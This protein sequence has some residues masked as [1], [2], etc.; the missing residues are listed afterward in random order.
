MP[1]IILVSLKLIFVAYLYLFVWQTARA[2]AAH[3]GTGQY[4]G[5]SRPGTGL[6]V[7]HSDTQTGLTVDVRQPTVL[8]SGE[9]ADVVIE[10]A[11]ASKVHVRLVNETGVLSLYDLGSTTGT[12]VNG[13]R[14]GAPLKLAKGDSVQIGKTVMEVT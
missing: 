4:R 14:V 9:G 13:K 7:V 5:R 10:D 8:G 6:T 11:Y 12:Y 1:A 2:I 3:V